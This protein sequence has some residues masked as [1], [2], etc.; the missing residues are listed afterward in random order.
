MAML[1]SRL[2]V[3]PVR[4]YAEFDVDRPSVKKNRQTARSMDQMKGAMACT[5][6]H[7]DAV[8]K[9]PKEHKN[10]QVVRF[11]NR[12]FNAKYESRFGIR[13]LVQRP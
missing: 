9:S 6:N 5:G 1:L 7:L 11:E 8:V 2:Q 13:E 12:R 3:F 4:I 10:L